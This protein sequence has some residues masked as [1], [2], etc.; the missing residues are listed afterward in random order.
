[1]LCND[2]DALL[3]MAAERRARLADDY[4]S[5]NAAH[6]RR[7][8]RPQRV[9][10]RRPP[11]LPKAI[12]ISRRA[13]IVTSILGLWLTVWIAWGAGAAL[14][15]AYP[16]VVGTAFVTSLILGGQVIQRLS[17]AYYER[18]MRHR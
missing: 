6:S 9:E 7:R 18:Q 2:T 8:A 13:L 3:Q 1:M 11:R 10:H 16:L 17:S 12:H 5:A 14:L 15:F 4:E